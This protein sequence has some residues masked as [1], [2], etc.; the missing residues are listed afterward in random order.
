ML[1]RHSPRTQ[2]VIVEPEALEAGLS[3]YDLGLYVK[4]A[5][6]PWHPHLDDDVSVDGFIRQLRCGTFGEAN[7]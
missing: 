1:K 3:V 7:S 4:S 5:S 6:G 2:P